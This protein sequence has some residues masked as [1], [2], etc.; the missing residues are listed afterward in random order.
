MGEDNYEDEENVGGE[1]KPERFHV[2]GVV[3]GNAVLTNLV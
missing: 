3:G 2:A 1:Q